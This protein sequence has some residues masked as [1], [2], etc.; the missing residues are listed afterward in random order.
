MCCASYSTS[1]VKG[2][3]TNSSSG[4]G[5]NALPTPA[6][7]PHDLWTALG[8]LANVLTSVPENHDIR[9][10]TVKLNGAHKARKMF[11]ERDSGVG[12]G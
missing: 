12:W 11:S 8:T 5:G 6:C 3:G 4:R 10:D 1:F 2:A 7:L 9:R